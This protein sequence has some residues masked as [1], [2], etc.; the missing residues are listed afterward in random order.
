MSYKIEKNKNPSH[1]C[2]LMSFKI[3]CPR[4]FLTTGSLIFFTFISVIFGSNQNYQ[5]KLERSRKHW[6]TELNLQ[7]L[8]RRI[9]LLPFL[10]IFVLYVTFLELVFLVSG[11][12]ITIL[13]LTEC[14]LPF[15]FKILFGVS[16]R[17]TSILIN[18]FAASR[19]KDF[20]PREIVFYAYLR[21]IK[22]WIIGNF[23]LSP[24]Q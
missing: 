17:L 9:T 10:C 2:E 5:Y 1:L 11:I 23:I 18:L 16:L 22:C 21:Y 24:L 3:I 12:I 4:S 15:Y 14:L 8:R 6:N 20:S 13:E 7:F 19:I